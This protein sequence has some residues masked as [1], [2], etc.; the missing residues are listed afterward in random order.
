MIKTSRS[1]KKYDF[2]GAPA[3]TDSLISAMLSL[4]HYR[5][6]YFYHSTISLLFIYACELMLGLHVFRQIGP[7]RR[8]DCLASP[9]EDGDIPL[10]ALP[11]DATSKLAVFFFILSLRA[12]RL[13]SFG[14][15]RLGE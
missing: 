2:T 5:I 10:S 14:M 8:I 3:T 11:N 9:H 13:K 4:D 12:E 6:P 15:T 7:P 1:R